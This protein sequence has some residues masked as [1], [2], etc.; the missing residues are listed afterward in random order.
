V[1]KPSK[2]AHRLATLVRRLRSYYGSPVAPPVRDP[3][4]LLLWE[5]VGYLADDEKRLAAFGLLQTSIGTRPRDI[6]DATTPKL[7]AVTRTG[8][9][10]AVAERAERLRTIAKR[11]LGEWDGDLRAVLALPLHEARRELT[12]F[13]SMGE[14]GAERILLLCGAH[15]VLALDSNALRVLTRLG[16]GRE[17]PDWTKTYRAAQAAADAE[18]PRT[19]VARRNAFLLLRQHGQTLCRRSAPRCLECPL[20][21][22]CPT[23][24]KRRA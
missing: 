24:L 10:V 8:G 23:G 9:G 12:R 14:A 17:Y 13:P 5:Q 20:R 7:Q 16:Y 19:T 15:P 3:Y 11:V 1:A 18:L 6:I 22:D 21:S 2:I 4:L